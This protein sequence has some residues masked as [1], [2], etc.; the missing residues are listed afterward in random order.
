MPKKVKAARLVLGGA[1]E[2][3]HAVVGLPGH[4]HP[5]IAVPLDQP[6]LVTSEILDAFL[7]AHAE[8]V[9]AAA[10][11]WERSAP[12]GSRRGTADIGEFDTPPA[13]VELV[14]LDA[15]WS[16]STRRPRASSAPRA[17]APPPPRAAAARATPPTSR[18]RPAPSPAPSDPRPGAPMANGYTHAAREST[19]GNETNTPTLSTKVIYEPVRSINVALNPKPMERDDEVRNVDE[20]LAVLPEMYD[21]TWELESA[22]L[23]RPA[24][25]RARDDAR[26]TRPPPPGTASSP[27]PTPRRSRP[28]RPGTSGPPRTGPPA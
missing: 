9:T 7:A 2:C 28:A 17:P 1:P 3:W 19:P 24:R 14:E 5:T 23:P 26:L 25:L 15:A 13:P 12:S 6:G 18:P 11:A 16:T 21:P 22:R 20:P 10:A 27:T 4:F 8:K